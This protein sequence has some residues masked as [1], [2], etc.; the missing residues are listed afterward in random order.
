MLSLQ[1]AVVG[2]RFACNADY[3]VRIAGGD[4]RCAK[5]LPVP[6]MFAVQYKAAFAGYIIVLLDTGSSS[7]SVAAA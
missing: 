4:V 6:A 3:V 5:F 7:E 1:V 2:P